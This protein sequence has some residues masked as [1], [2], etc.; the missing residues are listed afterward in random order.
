MKHLRETYDQHPMVKAAASGIPVGE[1]TQAVLAGDD[2]D[3]LA[4]LRLQL[5]HQVTVE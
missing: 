1:T 3:P 4:S 5:Q 2:D